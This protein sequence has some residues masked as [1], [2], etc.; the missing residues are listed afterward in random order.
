MDSKEWRFNMLDKCVKKCF[1]NT[2]VNY[3][4]DCDGLLNKKRLNVACKD[5][6]Y[7]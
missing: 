5:C 6:R 2:A 4:G 7:M 3:K 1:I